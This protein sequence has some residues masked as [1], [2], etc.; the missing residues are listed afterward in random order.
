MDAATDRHTGTYRQTKT[1][2]QTG[3]QSVSQSGRQTVRKVVGQ[4][5]QINVEIHWRVLRF[6]S[7]RV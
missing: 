7:N 6:D 3:R 4:T 1:G 2:I 5:L